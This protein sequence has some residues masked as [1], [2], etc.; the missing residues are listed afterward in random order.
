MDQILV[1][2]VDWYPTLLSAAGLEIGY[3][4][5]RRMSEAE[6]A[7][8]RFDHIPY[9][10]VEIDGKDIWNAIQFGEYDGEMSYEQRELVLDLDSHVLNCTFN[11][12]GAIRKGDWKFIR[13][14]NEARESPT[15]GG[16]QWQRYVTVR[17]RVL[18]FGMKG[19]IRN[20]E[21][22]RR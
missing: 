5:S 11:S 22:S 9:G 6:D 12:C 17:V 20:V 2:M 19:M 18:S 21:V 8:T 13:G 14:A 4:R 1:H 15:I 16:I 10:T 7:D 3:H